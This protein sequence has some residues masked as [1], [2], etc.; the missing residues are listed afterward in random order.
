MPF[1]CCISEYA[2]DLA[3]VASAVFV[4]FL[5]VAVLSGVLD[6]SVTVSHGV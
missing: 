3:F 4:S 6:V 5:F 1:S 2:S